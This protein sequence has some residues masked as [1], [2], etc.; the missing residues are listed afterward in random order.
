MPGLTPKP[1]LSIILALAAS[2]IGSEPT[3]A[4]DQHGL[5]ACYGVVTFG[6]EN[7]DI[8]LMQVVTSAQH[9]SFYQNRTEKTPHCPVEVDSCQLKSFVVPGDLLLVGPDM[10]DFACGTFISPIARRVKNQFRETI[11]FV[12]LSELKVVNTARPSPPAWS[13]TWYRSAEAEIR[14][15]Q[16]EAGKI[17][18]AG[19]ATYGAFDPDRVKRGAVNIG[20]LEGQVPLPNANMIALGEGY[21]GATPLGDDR[22]D[23]R[24]RLRLFGPYLVVEDNGGCG[25]NNVSFTGVYM[26]LK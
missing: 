1:L 5:R 15:E 14:I 3:R 26:R 16:E 25:G 4:R 18:I 13:G 9:M 6:R 7:P 11:G 24:A 17:R 12:P 10:D 22:S 21:D 20:A 19:R 23:C 2:V 8:R